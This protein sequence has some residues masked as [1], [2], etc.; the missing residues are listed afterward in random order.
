MLYSEAANA[1]VRGTVS[2][3]GLVSHGLYPLEFEACIGL[4]LQLAF[5][6]LLAPKKQRSRTPWP[7]ETK[8]GGPIP[9]HAMRGSHRRSTVAQ[10]MRIIAFQTNCGVMLLMV[11]LQRVRFGQCTAS[12]EESLMPSQPRVVT[13]SKQKLL[14]RPRWNKKKDVNPRK[15]RPR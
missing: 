1:A 10:N 11:L 9:C 12:A 5:A 2:E 4:L 14:V 15:K 7:I 13:R 8:R 6:R 3:I